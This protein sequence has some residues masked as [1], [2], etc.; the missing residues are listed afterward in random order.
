[1]EAQNGEMIAILDGID[2][3][4]SLNYQVR[5]SF[6]ANEILE[7]REFVPCVRRDPG[8]GYFIVDFDR[9]SKTKI[10]TPFYTPSPSVLKTSKSRKIKNRRRDS[11]RKALLEDHLSVEP[12][13]ANDISSDK[14]SFSFCRS[15]RS[16]FSYT[17][18]PLG[19]I[20]EILMDMAKKM[21][22]FGRRSTVQIE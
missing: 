17:G 10:A 13:G 20:D 1:M 21:P 3:I 15:P 22:S 5:W 7:G 12:R 9:L 6:K 8:T 2:E 19:S 18:S 4:S 14:N 11:A 16:S